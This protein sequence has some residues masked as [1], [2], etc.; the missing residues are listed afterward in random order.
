MGCALETTPS[1][2]VF[3]IFGISSGTS[4]V[5]ALSLAVSAQASFPSPSLPCR[6]WCMKT[7]DTQITNP[8]KLLSAPIMLQDVSIR[9]NAYLV[10]ILPLD[11]RD[12]LF[13]YMLAIGRQRKERF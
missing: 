4:V 7:G 13:L 2:S 12:Q 5:Y 8:I 1:L 9:R 3:R 10:V 11:C 6:D